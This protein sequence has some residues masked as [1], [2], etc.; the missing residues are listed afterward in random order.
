M[1]GLAAEL[2]RRGIELGSADSIVGTSAGAIVGAMLVTGRDLDAL[3]G[4]PR[5]P[6][7]AEPPP[8]LD[9]A[10]LGAA[11]SLLAGAAAD[12]AADPDAA[13]RAVG[14]LVI[15]TEPA[16]PAHIDRMG[17]L[18]GGD[19]WPDD[20]LRIVVVEAESGQR[21]IWDNASGVGLA[22]AVAASRSFPGT[23]PPVVVDDR[24]YIDG[25][26]WS[27]TN[28]DVAA[29]SDVLLIV[30]PLAHRFPRELLRA[31]LATATA[32]TVVQFT[33]D[34]ATIE[35]FDAF[36]TNPDGLAGWPDAFRAGVRQADTLARQLAD[37]AW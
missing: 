35:V 18:A 19:T 10:L 7:V 32:G 37:S 3:A 17:W 33:P 28:A 36:A 1:A 30:E 15:G 12:P 23:F 21:R 9:P 34:A 26:V 22:T 4:N 24:Y 13:R 25:G 29:D 20:R 6:G 31:E 16:Q 2:R 14:R 27:G 11:F 8:A 5:T